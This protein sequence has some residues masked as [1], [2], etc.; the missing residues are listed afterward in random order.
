MIR[1][2]V[3]VALLNFRNLR[4]RFWPS[5][6]IVAGMACVIG[7][8]LS[9]LSVT[10]GLRQAYL[11]ID[12]PLNAI[13]VARGSA[14]EGA[15]SI[16]RAQARLVLNA[17][18]IARGADGAPI[19]DATVMSG[20]QTRRVGTGGRAYITLR[21]FGPKGTALRPKFRMLQGRMFRPGSHELIAGYRAQGKFQDTGLGGHIIMPDGEWRI[22]GIFRIDDLSD[23]QVI[24]DTETVMQ[25]MRRTAYNRVL[26]RLTSPAAF[27]AFRRAL[28]TN[29]A[30]SLDVYRWSE[31]NRK[32]SDDTNTFFHVLIYGVS[33]ILAIGALF[34][35]FNTMYAAIERRA[36]EIATLRAMGFSAFAVAVSVMLEAAALTVTGALLGALVAW[37]LYDGVP[38]GMGS[39]LFTLRVSPAMVGL[40]VL[41]AIAVAVLGGLLPS[42]RAARR[43]VSEALRAT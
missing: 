14:F 11:N 20:V 33:V 29:P 37:A 36:R 4:R 5:L 7:V 17:P 39:D 12:D 43:T 3:I 23:G 41:W 6:V 2:I 13:V 31:W 18:G 30:L 34:G 10:D 42:V 19:A 1:Q 21:T 16:P 15:S 8:M 26:V 28:T 40:A 9:M 24:G 25:T 27:T 38:S 35:C 32:I 22:V